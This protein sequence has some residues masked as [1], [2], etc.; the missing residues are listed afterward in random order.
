MTGLEGVSEGDTLQIWTADYV[1]V[2]WVDGG[3]MTVG[4]DGTATADDGAGMDYLTTLL[5]VAP[6]G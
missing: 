5:I 6:A 3:T 2:E 1:T 4:A